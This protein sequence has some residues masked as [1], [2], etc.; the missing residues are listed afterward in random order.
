MS[1]EWYPKPGQTLTAVVFFK[2]VR[3]IIGDS[4]YT[5][6]FNSAVGTP[7]TFLITGPANVAEA[8]LHGIELSA[9]S[10][11]DHFDLL[12]D[13]LPSWAK[14]LGVSANYTY[15]DSDQKFYRDGGFTYCPVTDVKN[16][17]MQIYGCDTNGLPFKGKL[18]MQ[19][20]AKNAANFALRYD[21]GAF[22]GRLAYNW[23]GRSLV[24]LTTAGG[25]TCYNNYCPGGT[26][27]D[28]ATFGLQG[29]WIGL[30]VYQEAYGQW[31]GGVNYTFNKKFSMSFSVSN[32]NNV[33]VRQTQEQAPG[34]MGV[35][36]MFPGR[37]YYL[38]GRYEF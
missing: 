11:L 13:K 19:G 35:S 28:P 15:I 32:L 24:G 23:N 22:S 20:V 2:N 6:T 9:D 29:T 38:S 31:D 26:S 27:A 34:V 10:Y 17:G 1:L 16:S 37:S 8:K 3:D 18:P 21:S 36:W 30:P 14:G 12:K 25:G 4:T 7:Q 33:V 5:R